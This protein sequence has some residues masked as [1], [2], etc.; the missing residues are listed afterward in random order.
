WGVLLVTAT[1]ALWLLSAQCRLSRRAWASAR[2][3]ILLADSWALT[4]SK[5]AV[6]SGDELYAPSACVRDLVKAKQLAPRE[7]WR[8]LDRGLVGQPSSAP[9]G[10]ALPMFAN[11]EI[12]PV[13]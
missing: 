4:W 9:L 7:H 5:V 8:V 6:R 10:A 13:L 12:E 11:V 2:L 3:A 1:V